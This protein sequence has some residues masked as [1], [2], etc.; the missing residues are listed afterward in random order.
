M[1]DTWRSERPPPPEPRLDRLGWVIFVLRAIPFALTCLIGF[2][3]LVLVRLVERQIWGG[4]RPLSRYLQQGVCKAFFAISGIR[5]RYSGRPMTGAGAVVANHS[6]WIDIFTL[7]APMRVVFVSKA[8]VRSWP[9]IGLLARAT[10]TVFINRDRREAKAQQNVFLDRLLAGDKLLFFPEGTSTDGRRVLSFKATLFGPFF[11]AALRD[12]LKIQP[13]T[14]IYRAAKGAAPGFYGWWGDMEFG[15]HLSKV[16]GARRQGMVEVIY[17]EP[18]SVSDFANRK[19]L[20][21]A[22]EEAVRGGM[23]WDYQINR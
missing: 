20:A 1:S 5:L 19:A 4:N 7:S 15:S 8:E 21:R 16:L 10:G 11:D 3:L 14:V 17:H 12:R 9:G 13:V 23:P 22:C 2:V 18:L 6:S